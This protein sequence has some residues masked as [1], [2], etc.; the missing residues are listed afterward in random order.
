MD[1]CKNHNHD[2]HF[3]TKGP[4]SK[5]E[6][7]GLYCKDCSYREY[8]DKEEGKITEKEINDLQEA[9]SV[10]GTIHI[11]ELGDCNVDAYRRDQN[12]DDK[13]FKLASMYGATPGFSWGKAGSICA[14]NWLHW[15]EDE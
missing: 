14:S 15:S 3:I 8:F 9:L 1:L 12:R 11:K 10:G 13:I 4:W 5:S 2:L 6:I 7:I